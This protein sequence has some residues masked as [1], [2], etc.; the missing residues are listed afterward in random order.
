MLIFV[1][2]LPLQDYKDL[3][4]RLESRSHFTTT[5]PAQYRLLVFS[6]VEQTTDSLIQQCENLLKE[7]QKELVKQV[8]AADLQYS[9]LKSLYGRTPSLD[10]NSAHGQIMISQGLKMATLTGTNNSHPEHPDRFDV[11]AQ[12]VSSDCFSSGRHYWEVDVRSSS[13]CR[14]GICLNSMGRKGRESGLGDN[15]ESWCLE[16]DKNKYFARHNNQKI[17]LSVPGNPERFGFFLDCE[18]GELKCFWD[19]RVLHVFRGNFMDP[20]KPALGVGFYGGGFYGGGSVQF[21]SF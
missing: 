2:F 9:T 11:C 8:E 6:V 1:Y 17:D 20:V 10:Q 21:S 13:L 14:I 15:P 5:E 7:I 3:L 18:A 16:K 4:H 19:S 12:V